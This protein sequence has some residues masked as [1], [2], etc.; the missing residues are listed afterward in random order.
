MHAIG[1]FLNRSCG[2]IY[3][4]GSCFRGTCKTCGLYGRK[5]G[6]SIV[7][8]IFLGLLSGRG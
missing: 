7:F 1:A 5:E 8:F 3:P 4:A 2:I 6:G